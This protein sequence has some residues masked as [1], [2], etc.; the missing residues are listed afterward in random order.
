[1][2]NEGEDVT[3]SLVFPKGDVA[4]GP[5]VTRWKIASAPLKGTVYYNSYGTNLAKNYGGVKD[6]D[7]ALPD[8]TKFGGATL[9]I[10]GGSTEPELVAGGD[11]DR[12]QC[13]VCHS[14]AANGSVL[15][16]QRGLG[17]DR[18]FSTYEPTI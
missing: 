3:V 1:M 10:R 14:V 13:R 4:Y 9:A 6:E 8:N 17:P 2:S 18:A 15:I 5:L 12:S 11:G 16:T 7:G